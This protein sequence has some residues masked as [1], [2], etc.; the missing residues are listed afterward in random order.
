MLTGQKTGL[1]CVCRALAD[2]QLT[3]NLLVQKPGGDET[4]NLFFGITT[5]TPSQFLAQAW[6][7]ANKKACEL[8]WI[9]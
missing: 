1:R 8:G 3:G 9:A 5:F 7:T 2:T 6:Q 4:E